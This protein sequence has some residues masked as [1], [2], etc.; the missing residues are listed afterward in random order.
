MTALCGT[1]IHGPCQGN[2]TSPAG[3]L[4]ISAI[5]LAV[6]K[7]CGHG[8]K[9]KLPISGEECDTAGVLYV[10]DVVLLM[11]DEDFVDLVTLWEEIQESTFM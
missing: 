8:T 9:L 2:T 6:Y 1:I 4:V 3:C 10:D 7:K 11:M 5:L